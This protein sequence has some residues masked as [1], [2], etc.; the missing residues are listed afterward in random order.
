MDY[1]P[2]IHE[3]IY[4]HLKVT[5]A[6]AGEA[7]GGKPVVHFSYSMNGK[8]WIDCGEAFDMRQGKWIGAKFGY[9][10]VETDPKADRG[11]VDADWIRID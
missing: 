2:A 10:S 7:H 1:K 11:W 5:N 3:D 4:L 6:Q 8:K 9:V